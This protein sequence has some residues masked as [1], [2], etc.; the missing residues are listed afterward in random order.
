MQLAYYRAEED[1]RTVQIEE[2]VL[3][4]QSLSHQQR[5]GSESFGRV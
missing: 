3:S 1:R 5:Q 4:F 2:F